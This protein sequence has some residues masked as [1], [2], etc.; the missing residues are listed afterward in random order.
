MDAVSSG[1]LASV[2]GHDTVPNSPWEMLATTMEVRHCRNATVNAG[3]P[4]LCVLGP[5]SPIT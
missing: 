4:G 2:K 1:V 5:E 3:R